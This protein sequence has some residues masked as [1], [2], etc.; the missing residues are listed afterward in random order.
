MP[1]YK[2]FDSNF[3]FES[4]E[5]RFIPIDPLNADYQGYL[6]WL[7][8]GNT[9]GLPFV[10]P[11]NTDPVEAYSNLRVG[12]SKIF[13]GVDGRV[14]YNNAGIVGETD[15]ASAPI[16]ADGR[17]TLTS[18]TPANQN[19][20]AQTT[21]YYTPYVGNRISLYNGTIWEIKPFSQL[22]VTI[23]STTNTNYDVFLYDN[24]GTLTLDL[25][26]WTNDTTRATALTTQDGVLVKTG[27]LARRY[28]GTIRTNATSGQVSSNTS[29]RG[30]WN[31]YNRMPLHLLAS[32]TGSYLYQTN[33][34]RAAG[35]NT[36]VG[37][38]RVHVVCGQPTMATFTNH[39]IAETS[40]SGANPIAGIGINKTNGNDAAIFGSALGYM[41]DITNV[42]SMIATYDNFLPEGFS[43]IQRVE[44]ADSAE[45]WYSSVTE[46]ILSIQMGLRGIIWG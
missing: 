42:A 9:L 20:S 17:L 31:M 34:W 1:T 45:M 24:S 22:S 32:T 6:Q 44:R 41:T 29:I 25:T 13:S 39:S 28:I 19:A 10:P 21:L 35:G 46:T 43:Y 2:E 5:G 30:V 12:Y 38:A 23:P 27:A 7:A 18:N 36:T 16:V 14:L 33:S 37:A 4:D 26:A 40:S 8:D 3:I 11:S 15:I